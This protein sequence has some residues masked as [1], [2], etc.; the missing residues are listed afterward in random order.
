MKFWNHNHCRGYHFSGKGHAK[1][2]CPKMIKIIKIRDTVE[3]LLPRFYIDSAF[4]SKL[5]FSGTDQTSL[6]RIGPKI[7]DTLFYPGFRSETRWDFWNLGFYK[8]HFWS[9]RSGS[10]PK[11]SNQ[12]LWSAKTLW[13]CLYLTSLLPPDSP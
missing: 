11:V 2:D 8:N 12:V 5:G 13:F 4:C 7:I 1:N 3:R 9:V 6:A 10:D